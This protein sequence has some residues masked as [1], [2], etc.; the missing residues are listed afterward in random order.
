M[1]IALAT[2]V[3]GFLG[4]AY[5][6]GLDSAF[7]SAGRAPYLFIAKYDIAVMP[8]FVLMGMVVSETNIGSDLYYTVHRWLGH[9]RGGLAIATA[10]ACALFG[11][12]TGSSMSG[13]MVMSKVA[14]PEM[15]RYKYD[16]RLSTGVIAASSTMGVLIPPS[17][18]FIMYGILT[19]VSI[20]K[21][22]MAGVIPGILEA[23]FYMITIYILC[24]FNPQMGPPGPKTSFKMK[25]FSLKNT[26][27][28]VAL[29]L[30]VMGGIYGGV[31]TPTE[32]GAIGAFGAITIAAVMGRFSR[33]AFFSSLRESGLMAAMILLM[34]MGV[35]IFQKFMAAS[36]LPFWLG[37]FI[38]GLKAPNIV[39]MIAI[40]IMYIIAGCFLPAMLAIILTIPIIYP[41]ILAMGFDPIWYGV[42][43]VRMTEIGAITPP[44]GMECFVLSGVSG[45]PLGTIYR[46]V[47]PFIIADFCHVALLIAVPSLSLFLPNM[48]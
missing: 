39:I 31:F 46:G 26:W 48:M 9:L 10:G 17:I 13:I 23:I 38:T 5:V 20:G 42:I 24:H 6:K 19:E 36:Q 2:A 41:A 21:L 22:F 3:V 33:K 40:V 34:L 37:D 28:M 30:L 7:L 43:M 8:M 47:V 25:I 29:F 14:L 18:A 44:V 15:Q 35:S 32:A 45:V 11:A 1:W 12:I 27:P 16:D 4:I